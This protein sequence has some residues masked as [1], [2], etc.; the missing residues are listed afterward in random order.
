MKAQHTPLKEARII[1]FGAGSSA[2]GVA[3][4]IA[5]LISKETG[6]SFDEAKKARPPPAPIAISHALEQHLW[7]WHLS[8]SEGKTWPSGSQVKRCVIAGDSALPEQA[9]LIQ[10]ASYSALPFSNSYKHC[11]GPTRQT[12]RAS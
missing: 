1:F 9:L 5:Q 4:M 11:G 3:T 6:I 10:A 7:C 12:A 2:V 8:Q